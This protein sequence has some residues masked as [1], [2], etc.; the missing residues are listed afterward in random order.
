MPTFDDIEEHRPELAR[1]YI[2]LLKAQPGRPIAL[3]AP[4]RVG[5]TFFLDEDLTP[6]ARAAGLTP[7][8]AD[9]WLYRSDP[10]A[11]L[12][13]SIEEALDD[14]IVPKSA[15][16]KVARTPVRKMG[17]MGASLELG[18]E[19]KR[20][21]LP[22]E[23]ALRLD[24]L[25][26]RLVAVGRR[27]VLLM[28]DEAQALAEAQDAAGVMGSLRA[29]LQKRKRDVFAVFTGSSQDALAAMMAAAG[30][31][32]YQFAQLH[33]FPVLGEGFLGKLAH[34]F[35]LV[36]KGRRLDMEAL[37]RAF[38]HLGFRPALMK[39][40]V[41]NLSAEGSTDVESALRRL[42]T[43]AKNIVGWRGLIAPMSAF[44][45]HLLHLL[46]QKKPPLGREVL[47]A[48][49]RADGKTVTVAKV[50][51][52]LDRL[53]RAGVLRSSSGEYVIDDPLLVDYLLNQ[54]VIGLI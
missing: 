26:A 8:Y 17:A 9:I 51:A 2:D 23:P 5:K 12:N 16:G 53:K 27:P 39:D 44:D 37:Q 24:A 54:G 19:P 7:V 43:D 47:Q 33:N 20:R 15:V 28:L 35:S 21:D 14:V 1:G 46:A 30:G 42:A 49:P 45:R 41:K 48:L 52:A 40:L 29:V 38:E 6:A 31:P 50:R 34:H 22:E 18:D 36:H 11:A 25:V 3:F 32:M 13:H 10:L 4:R